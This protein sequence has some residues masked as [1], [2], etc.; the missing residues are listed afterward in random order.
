[1]LSSCSTNKWDVDVSEITIDTKVNRFE[2][3]LFALQEDNLEKQV[4]SLK[5]KYGDFYTH[6]VQDM[7]SVGPPDDIGTSRML[8]PFVQ[9]PTMKEVYE[10]TQA[11]FGDF[12]KEESQLTEA[13]Q[14]LK[15]HFPQIATPEIITY[16]SGFNYA[17]GVTKTQ[18][19]CG[20]EMFLGSDCSYYTKLRIPKYKSFN[21][22]PANLPVEMIKAWVMTEFYATEQDESTL[23]SNIVYEG[24]ILLLMDVLFP[25]KNDSIKIGYSQYEMDW[26]KENEFNI[27][28]HFIEHNLLYS[29]S[30]NEIIKYVGE[31]PFT[32]GFDKSSPARTGSWVGWQIVRAFVEN[33]PNVSLLELMKMKDAQLLL[34]KSGY[35]PK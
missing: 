7:I 1:M 2:R 9:D 21:M 34:N 13:L 17:L 32:T 11:V 10:K 12:Q 19:G 20:L 28:A 25:N 4:A 30:K 29:K 31:G 24:K 16:M 8:V 14:R 22:T 23:L 33:N 35:K 6:F 15:Y 3:D 26:C 27:W 18:L 5:L